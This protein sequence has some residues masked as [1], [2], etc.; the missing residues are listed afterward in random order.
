MTAGNAID[1]IHRNQGN[2][3][4]MPYAID[5]ELCNKGRRFAA[6]KRR[7]KFSFGFGNLEAIDK[8]L[9]ST[10]CRGEEHQVVMIWSLTS[11]KQRV[12]ADGIEVHFSRNSVTGKF[13][14]QWTM[15]SGHH[16]TIMGAWAPLRK[17]P[18]NFD[19]RV[20]G[21]SFWDMPKIYQLGSGTPRQTAYL[22][23]R[24]RTLADFSSQE[25]SSN[26]SSPQ[27]CQHHL[28]PQTSP[29]SVTMMWDDTLLSNYHN[30]PQLFKDN[31][32]PSLDQALL[33]LVNMDACP[34]VT[35]SP[36]SRSPSITELSVQSEYASTQ[37]KMEYNFY[38]CNRTSFTSGGWATNPSK[39]HPLY[40]FAG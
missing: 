17:D 35:Q 15:K 20:D 30:M 13:E 19:L 8:G 21:L 24:R 29:A 11:G 25:S 23:Q 37:P 7:V 28:V 27:T 26:A 34:E 2:I 10:E 14:C 6:T 33:S 3:S 1:R 39:G 36:I 38:S 31:M 9:S 12:L 4:S 40:S 22:P 18:R 16:I 32:S 5:S